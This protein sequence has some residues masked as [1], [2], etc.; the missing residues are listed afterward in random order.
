MAWSQEDSAKMD[1]AAVDAQNELLLGSDGAHPEFSTASA[2]DLVRWWDRW[3]MKAGHKRLGRILV[4]V[5]RAEQKARKH[6]V[7]AE[8]S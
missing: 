1:S 8:V 6:Q 7:P 5:A 3:Y 4:E 2:L